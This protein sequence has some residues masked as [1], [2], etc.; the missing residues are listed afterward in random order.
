MF[1]V[2]GEVSFEVDNAVEFYVLGTDYIERLSDN[3]PIER[4]NDNEIIERL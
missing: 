3:D 1:E 2:S 4:S